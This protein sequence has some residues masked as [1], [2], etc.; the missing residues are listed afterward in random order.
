MTTPGA[1]DGIGAAASNEYYCDN[2]PMNG[3]GE[4]R[5]P[6]HIHIDEY[7]AANSQ[8]FEDELCELLRIPKR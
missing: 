4:A 8:R 6:C 2:Q 1:I 3:N 7:L 5:L